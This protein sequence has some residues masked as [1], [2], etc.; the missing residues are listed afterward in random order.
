M[1][2]RMHADTISLSRSG[3]VCD[4]K[5]LL[6]ASVFPGE[7]DWQQ[8]AHQF[9]GWVG[10]PCHGLIWQPHPAASWRGRHHTPPPVTLWSV[11]NIVHPVTFC[12]ML[13]MQ[14]G[15]SKPWNVWLIACSHADDI[16][17][18]TQPRFPGFSSLRLKLRIL[19]R[20]H[21]K[22]VQKCVIW[23]W[24]RPVGQGDEK[25]GKV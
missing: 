3:L 11:T 23:F 18:L 12:R 19:W 10:G 2:L 17:D 6:H 4:L 5:A 24:Q 8:V 7:K 13:N 15:H 1:N 25:A 9:G 16:V 22:A 14:L 20:S 21:D